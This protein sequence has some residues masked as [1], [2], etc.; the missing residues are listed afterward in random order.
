[1]SNINPH[2][3]KRITDI[4]FKHWNKARGERMFPAREDI[5]EFA[6]K[7]DGIWDDVFIIDVFPMI[8]SN[9]YRF[10]YTGANLNKDYFKDGSGKFVKNIVVGFLESSNSKYDSVFEQ[11]RPLQEEEEYTSSETGITIKYRQILLPL[12][13]S[14]EGDVTSII[15]GMRFISGLTK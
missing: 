4:L 8:Q 11:K 1:M 14:D 7:Q 2:A 15:G 9:G 12:G 13:R 6:I 3:H 5:D 10:S